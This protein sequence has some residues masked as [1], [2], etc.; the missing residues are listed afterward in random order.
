M[1]ENFQSENDNPWANKDLFFPGKW[2][3]KAYPGKEE[4]KKRVCLTQ[5]II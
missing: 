4:E 2:L 1:T 5:V 3:L